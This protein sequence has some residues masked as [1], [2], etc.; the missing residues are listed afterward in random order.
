MERIAAILMLSLAAAAFAA[1]D[2]I[3]SD[4]DPAS[5]GGIRGHIATP[6][7]PIEQVLAI[8]FDEPGLVYKGLV[9][10]DDRRSF[11]FRGLPMRKYDLIVIYRDRFYEGLKLHDDASTLT[12][13]DQ[14]KIEETIRKSEPFFLKKRTHRLEG[15]TGRGGEAR[16]LCTYL[17]DKSSFE[18]LEKLREEHRRTF[19]LVT[20]KNVGP[21]WQIVRAR[22]LHPVFVQPD[23]GNPEHIFSETLG[24]VRVT[25]QVRDLGSVNLR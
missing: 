10:G 15:A 1:S 5:P 16:G 23:E 17:R 19:K 21:G 25:D 12:A 8:P 2:G 3:Y 7:A 22:D 18:G 9:E 11:S 14:A 4:P 20:L 6:S 24:G 13:E